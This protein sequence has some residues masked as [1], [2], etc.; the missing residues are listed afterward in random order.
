MQ[1]IALKAN[2]CLFENRDL[3]ESARRHVLDW[4]DRNPV[5]RLTPAQV[6][7]EMS[8]SF[9]SQHP[10]RR[11]LLDTTPR[12]STLPLVDRTSRSSTIPLTSNRPV[13]KPE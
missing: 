1:L 5:C 13:L 8:V 10:P 6:V 4:F 12:N 7:R 3:E 11:F 9:H 2:E